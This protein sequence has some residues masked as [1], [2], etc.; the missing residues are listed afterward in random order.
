MDRAWS[1]KWSSILD[2]VLQ[3]NRCRMKLP[4][5]IAID[6]ERECYV[7]EIRVRPYP[8][9]L[10]RYPLDTPIATMVAWRAAQQ[11]E[12]LDARAAIVHAQQA[13]D[14][15]TSSRRATVTTLRDDVELWIAEKLRPDM[16]PDTRA[17]FIRFLRCAA[18]S[19]LGRYPRH[20]IG[21]Q[22][23]TALVAQWERAGMPV[24]HDE[25]APDRPR[26][27]RR[28]VPP[29]PLSAATVNKIRTAIIQFYDAMNLGL[30]LPNPARAIPW[31]EPGDPEPRGIP[32]ADA[33]A[34]CDALPAGTRTAARLMLMCT[35]GLRGVEIM[36]IQP[37]KDWHRDAQTLVIRTAKHGKTRTLPLNE[38][39][40]AALKEL[41]RLNGWG[42]FTS[43][44]AARMFHVAVAK[45]GRAHLEPLRPYDLRHVFGT[46][47]YRLTGDVKATSEALGHK[48]LKTTMRYVEAAV[49][50]NVAALY[51]TVAKAMPKPRKRRT[52]GHLR[53]VK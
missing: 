39:A 33:L 32:M 44:P 29:G 19:E 26:R 46:E 30:D 20:A 4:I 47:A 7:V 43:A 37:G 25:T 11:R 51:E 2:V 35:L 41:D 22:R 13:A 49:S 9:R 21:P 3:L 18:A 15:F 31:R 42:T 34:I 53:E 10:A 1:T 6:A 45:A 14:P 17:Q 12:L 50:K 27:R 8:K 16:H 48:N 23:W 28:I 24:L 5:G 40:T 52:R 36:R 38:R